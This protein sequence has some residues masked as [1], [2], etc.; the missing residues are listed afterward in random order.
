MMSGFIDKR[1]LSHFSKWKIKITVAVNSIKSLGGEKEMMFY[2]RHMMAVLTYHLTSHTLKYKLKYTK[3]LKG[4]FY[5]QWCVL[6]EDKDNIFLSI[7]LSI[8]F[9]LRG[10]KTA[11]FNT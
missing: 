11:Q 2:L 5:Y 4:S 6:P 10:A 7:F 1:L 8:S 9:K 3:V